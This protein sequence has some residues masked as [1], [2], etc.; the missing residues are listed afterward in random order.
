MLLGALACRRAP[1]PV[2]QPM[3]FSHQ[4]H[5]AA[6]MKCLT[7]HPGAGDEA[8]AQ[9]PTVADCLDCHHKARG[10]DPD[11]ARIRW[12]A[13][14]KLEIPWVRVDQL[15][16]HVY[17]SH[18]AHVTLAQM[19]CEDCHGDL[20]ERTRP[21]ALPDVSLTMAECMRCHQERGASNQ[22]KTCHR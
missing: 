2:T 10:S 16:G 14:N 21:L 6:N 18:A 5:I 15:P 11:E 13:T 20:R 1:A 4:R 9:L 7:C 3:A 22:C 19:K 8:R 12:F 17:F